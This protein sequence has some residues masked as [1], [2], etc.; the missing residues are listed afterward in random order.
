MQQAGQARER[1]LEAL[2]ARIDIPLPER[3]VASETE[4]REHSLDEQL[5]RAG[6]TRESYLTSRGL[7]EADLSAEILADARRFVKSGFILDQI[8]RTEDLGIEQEELNAYIVEQ[9]YRLGV[10]PD[11]LAQ[12]IVDQGQLGVAVTEVLRSKALDLLAERA[13]V[14]DEAGRPV[15]VKA[16]VA[17]A[18]GGTEGDAEAASE[19]D[20]GSAAADDHAGATADDDGDGDGDGDAEAAADDSAEDAGG[21]ADDA[22]GDAGEAGESGP[23]EVA[24]AQAG[25]GEAAAK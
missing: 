25:T 11:R 7:T 10:P 3:L 16:I 23:V 12:Q 13:T 21:D 17:E 4:R 9:A 22:S 5:E 8:A 20:A 24:T 18:Q 19:D 2:L 6:A 15:D 14:T 1:A